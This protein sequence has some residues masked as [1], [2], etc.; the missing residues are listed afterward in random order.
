MVSDSEKPFANGFWE[1]KNHLRIFGAEKKPFANGNHS[2]MVLLEAEKPFANFFW[3]QK[4]PFAN[5]CL[6]QR[7]T[8][9]TFCEWFLGTKKPFA[10]GF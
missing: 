7:K 8:T 3:E 5:G 10:N 6:E 1:Q 4:K 2:R 9:K